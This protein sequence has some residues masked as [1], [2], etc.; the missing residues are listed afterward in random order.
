MTLHRL[1]SMHLALSAICLA[2]TLL[3]G[4]AKTPDAEKIAALIDGMAAH[5]RAH[6]VSAFFKAVADDFVGEPVASPAI[7]KAQLKGLLAYYFLRHKNINIVIVHQDITVDG[8]Q[9]RVELQALTTGSR[10]VIPEQAQYFLIQGKLAK[11]ANTWWVTHARWEKMLA[12]QN[13]ERGDN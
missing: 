11:R 4:C 12:P 6:E 5:A 7:S 8:D 13:N 1:R 10:T 2:L 9:A 3:P